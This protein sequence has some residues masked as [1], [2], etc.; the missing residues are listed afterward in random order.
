MI[1]SYIARFHKKAL[2]AAKK[3]C[4]MVTVSAKEKD[5]GTF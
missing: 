2:T 3:L 4:N 1:F 5:Y